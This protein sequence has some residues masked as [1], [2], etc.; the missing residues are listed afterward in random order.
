MIKKFVSITITF[1]IFISLVVY[2]E[3]GT[4]DIQV[5]PNSVLIGNQVVVDI[6]LN[7]IIDVA[8]GEIILN[9]DASKLNL[10]SKNINLTTGSYIDL[11]EYSNTLSDTSGST[12]IV[13]G[14][15]KDETLINGNIS[16][17]TITFTSSGLGD[18]IF[19][20]D[21]NS[22][23]VKSDVSDGYIYESVTLG[24][25]VTINIYRM[26]AI[27]GTIALEDNI[28]P[29]GAVVSLY[30]DEV[31]IGSTNP[32]A[33]GSYSF[34]GL[35]DG[36]YTLKVSLLGYED[37]DASGTVASNSDTNI[38]ITLIRI[39]EDV[40][41]DGEIGIE[42]LVAIGNLF[43]LTST[44]DSFDPDA[45]VNDDNIIDLLDMIY[46]TRAIQ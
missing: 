31:L 20:L 33:D 22:K 37:G 45:D 15:K 2:A 24:N 1:L 23:L 10:S 40:N 41:R 8:G 12:K 34:E 4:I 39:K 16:I 6:S 11:Q 30:K 42:D 27:T 13:F 28:S 38:D 35:E 29:E 26:G 21:S 7:N 5:N 46:I 18:A 9:Y 32:S 19:S 3:A 43:G 17:G 44:D 25:S 14:L 36:D